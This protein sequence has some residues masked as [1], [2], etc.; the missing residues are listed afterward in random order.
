MRRQRRPENQ[1]QSAGDKGQ[2]EVFVDAGNGKVLKT[3]KEGAVRRAA[4]KPVD[5]TKQ[6]AGHTKEAVT[7]K[8]S[9]NQAMGK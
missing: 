7:G 6:A 9:T 8:E 4:E 5:L 2:T 1:D 3:E